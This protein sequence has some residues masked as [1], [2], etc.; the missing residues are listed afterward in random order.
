MDTSKQE[1]IQQC[2]K[3]NKHLGRNAVNQI[4]KR[5]YNVQLLHTSKYPPHQGFRQRERVLRRMGK[6]QDEIASILFG[7]TEVENEQSTII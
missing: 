4:L 2:I 5:T 6:T 7:D 1:Q 3:E